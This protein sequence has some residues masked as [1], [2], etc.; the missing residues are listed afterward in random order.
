MERSTKH[1][2]LVVFVLLA[3]NALATE[4]QPDYG[5]AFQQSGQAGMSAPVLG[6]CEKLAEI[7]T[8]MAVC[9]SLVLNPFVPCLFENSSHPQKLVKVYWTWPIQDVNWI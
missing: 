7:G 8:C 4:A 2:L 9:L 6:F 1:F 3:L 5:D